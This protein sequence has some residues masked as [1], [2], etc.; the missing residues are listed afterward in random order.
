[1][2]LAVNMVNDRT[3]TGYNADM[4]GYQSGDKKNPRFQTEFGFFGFMGS[5]IMHEPD[6][7]AR[8]LL[9]HKRKEI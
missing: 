3:I 2:D 6:T 9:L 1:M 5:E 7:E 8:W 4:W